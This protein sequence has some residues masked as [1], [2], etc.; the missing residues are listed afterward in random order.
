M[1]KRYSGEDIEF[2]ES[3]AKSGVSCESIGDELGV[4]GSAIRHILSRRGIK[5]CRKPLKEIPGEIWKHCPN[6]PDLL[7][8]NLGRFVRVS[9]N[10]MITGFIT[11]GGYVTLD[12]SGSGRFSAHRLIA[13]AFI[14]NPEN[15]PE[16]N[17]INGNKIDNRVANLEWVT[18]SENMQH[19]H[20]TGLKKPL[21]GQD[22]P[23]TALSAADI[24]A[25][26]ELHSS[27]IFYREIGDLYQVDRHTVSKHV[28]KYRRSIER[29]ETIP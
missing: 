22:H 25:C 1:R 26:A 28:N 6:I 29:S 16:V 20:L 19:A 23:R 2:I 3:Q 24:V 15:K 8:S 10:S 5:F 21:V 18:P 11:S 27:G 13:Q 12:V 4:S 9:S 14:P 17:H 7:I